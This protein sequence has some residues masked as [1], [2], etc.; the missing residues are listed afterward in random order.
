[1]Y[2]CKTKVRC[3]HPAHSRCKKPQTRNSS[4]VQSNSGKF[5]EIKY[6]LLM[7]TPIERCH[8]VAVIEPLKVQSQHF[9]SN[10]RL[11][12]CHC[13]EKDNSYYTYDT[14]LKESAFVDTQCPYLHY[15]QLLGKRFICVHLI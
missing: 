10:P 11:S 13:S 2:V 1:M 12:D 14:L 7:C 15:T 3:L 6:F 4:M 8:T 5:G 9:V